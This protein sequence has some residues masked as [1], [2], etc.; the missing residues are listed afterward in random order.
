M[1]NQPTTEKEQQDLSMREAMLPPKLRDWRAKLSAKAK[2]Q[3]HYRF[4]SLYA[5]VSHPVTLRAAWDKVRV[6]GGSPG[7]DGVSIDHIESRGWTPS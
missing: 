2:Q 1:E 5:M 7:V 3:K 4:Y 6:N